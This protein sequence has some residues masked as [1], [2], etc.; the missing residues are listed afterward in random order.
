MP[1]N[2]GVIED[3]IRTALAAA[4]NNTASAAFEQAQKDVPVRKVFKYGRTP[5]TNARIQGRQETRALSMREG[6]AEEG[7]RR[8][9][10]L[11]SAF[12]TDDAGR[13]LRG[14][15]PAVQT[16]LFPGNYRSRNR[17]NPS[18][19]SG[20]ERRLV[21]NLGGTNYLINYRPSIHGEPFPEP[22]RVRESDLSARGKYELKRRKQMSTSAKTGK[23]TRSAIHEGLGGKTLGGA[24][25]DS[26]RNAKA[27][28]EDRKIRAT[29]EAGNDEV[30]YAKYVEFGT[31][32]ARA[33]PFLRP[34]L[35]VAREMFPGE[36]K[37]QLAKFGT[38]VR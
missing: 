36:V 4:V 1:V 17:A 33:Q 38:V 6:L 27:D 21:G 3:A 26:L 29:I 34:A 30:T 2:V 7:V 31:R 18:S 9:L 16:A 19:A 28:K 5:R 24:L 14:S 25:R 8:R 35:A 11:P 13:R 20:M 10:G 23:V 22:D 32:H 37:A 12:P 15:Q